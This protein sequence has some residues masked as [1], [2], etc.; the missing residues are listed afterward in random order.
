MILFLYKLCVFRY[1]RTIFKLIPK[2]Q[3]ILKKDKIYK[4]QLS[5]NNQ[6]IKECYEHLSIYQTVLRRKHNLFFKVY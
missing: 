5:L 3:E 2:D 6:S 1:Q 4:Q